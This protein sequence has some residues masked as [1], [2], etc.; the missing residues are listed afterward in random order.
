MAISLSNTWSLPALGRQPT[1]FVEED[2]R[3][4]RNGE[5]YWEIIAAVPLRAEAGLKSFEH[6]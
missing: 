2:R 1:S 6:V 5:S 3:R 4:D